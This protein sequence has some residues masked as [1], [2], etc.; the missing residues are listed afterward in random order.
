MEKI[1]ND[2]TPIIIIDYETFENLK[3]RVDL[4]KCTTKLFGYRATIALPVIGEFWAELDFKN[5]MCKERVVVMEG[6][7][8]CLLSFKTTRHYKN[9]Q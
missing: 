9:G 1:E 4:T 2:V 8:E 6:Q 7:S 3:T 5:K